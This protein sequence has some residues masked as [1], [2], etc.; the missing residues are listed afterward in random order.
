MLRD[1]VVLYLKKKKK[2]QYRLMEDLEHRGSGLLLALVS[3]HALGDS[4]VVNRV[5]EVDHLG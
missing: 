3:G 5:V 4:F 2:N 1:T